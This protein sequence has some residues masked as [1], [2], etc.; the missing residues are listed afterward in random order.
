MSYATEVTEKFKRQHLDELLQ[1]CTE[2][3]RQLARRIYPGGV[4]AKE[5]DGMID[6]AHR[7][8][9]ANGKLK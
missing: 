7:T 1:Q 2:K 9:V 5:L 6:L 3:Q 4:P 8:L